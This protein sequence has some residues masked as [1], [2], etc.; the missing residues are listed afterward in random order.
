[1]ILLLVFVCVCV[2]VSMSINPF[3]FVVQLSFVASKFSFSKHSPCVMWWF[4]WQ[5]IDRNCVIEHDFDCVEWKDKIWHPLLLTELGGESKLWIINGYINDYNIISAYI[6]ATIMTLKC[7]RPKS[8]NCCPADRSFYQQGNTGN[9]AMI[10]ADFR[11]FSH[12]LSL[13]IMIL[14]SEKLNFANC[15]LDISPDFSMLLKF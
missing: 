5:I 4:H 8:L 6:W 13:L 15:S 11:H 1:M 2:C 10:F 12:H 14:N 7:V 9:N 3:S